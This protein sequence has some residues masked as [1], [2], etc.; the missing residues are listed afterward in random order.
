MNQMALRTARY[1]ALIPFV[2][3]ATL[4]TAV[5]HAWAAPTATVVATGLDAPKQAVVGPD[6]WVYVALS[7]HAAP[8]DPLLDGAPFN[9]SG[10]VVK[11]SP[12]G[13][14][15]PVAT[16]LLSRFDEGASV[17]PSGLAFWHGSLYIAQAI[18]D[19]LNGVAGDLI[20]S[21]ILKVVGS[22]TRTFTSLLAE[23]N[24]LSVGS[25]PDT[26]PFAMTVGADGQ[27]YVADGG[28][29]GVW[30]V[31]P[32]GDASLFVQFP[33]DPTVTGIAVRRSPRDEGRYQRGRSFGGLVVC[34]FGNG[35]SGFANGRVE[36]VDGEGHHTLVPTG[37]ITMPISPAYSPSGQ[38]Y[39]LQFATP[40]PN[41][42]PPF[43][44]GSG[45]IW[46]IAKNGAATKVLD[47]LNFPTGLC[48]AP[49]GTAYVTNNGILPGAG[50]VSGE[51]L[52]VV[53]L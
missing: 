23:S 50:T 47:G 38:L 10:G 44:P 42:G 51:L 33:G 48:F 14:V 12:D 31:A 6:G 24:D 3:A 25:A 19:P 36:M 53:G 7:G 16:G 34:L 4:A 8:T 22:R 13:T 27:L 29:N 28:A 41:P 26:N 30:R 40:N 17:G 45:A 5:T 20:S 9:K 46:S 2:C 39:I 18:Y 43:V 21:P 32:N 1:A 49:D 37:T 52:K 15:S 11:V 35:R